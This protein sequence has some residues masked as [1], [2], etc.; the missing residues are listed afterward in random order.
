MSYSSVSCP[1][2][3]MPTPASLTVNVFGA[4]KSGEQAYATVHQ[5][6]HACLAEDGGLENFASAVV[7]RIQDSVPDL[8]SFS[9]SM[10]G[11]YPWERMAN[12]THPL[13][14]HKEE[15]PTAVEVDLFA[16][17]S[18]FVGLIILNAL[19]GTDFVE[20]YPSALSD[21]QE[22]DKAFHCMA[23]GFPRWLPF[24]GLAKAHMARQRLLVAIDAFH[25]AL[26]K[27]A[28][29]ERPDDP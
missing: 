17:V 10:V 23:L 5:Q 24:S 29:G 3:A 19:L 8:V 12:P 27:E 20:L 6:A 18:N 28:V 9:E 7:S 11:Q 21:L 25:R 4:S 14:D 13:V 22:L 16:L 26:D 1:S 2:I 15:M